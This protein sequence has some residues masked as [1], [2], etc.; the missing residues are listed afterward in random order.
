MCVRGL[1]LPIAVLALT[2][3]AGPVEAL[4]EPAAWRL[5][6]S[7][8][9][10]YWVAPASPESGATE[11]DRMLARWALEAWGGL[12]EPPL[13][14]EPAPEGSAMVRIFW[15]PAGGGMYG[16]MRARRCRGG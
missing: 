2:A 13:G 4:Q 6:A 5:D 10:T 7:E 15:V 14:F 12:A 3:G 8:T 16:E 9:I 11:E 1:A